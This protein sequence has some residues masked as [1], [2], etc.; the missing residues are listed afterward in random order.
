[1]RPI[2][3]IEYGMH[4]LTCTWAH[5]YTE[6]GWKIINHGF[7]L[8]LII[9]YLLLMEGS[10]IITRLADNLFHLFNHSC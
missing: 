3:Q 1:M 5:I 7:M 10:Q 8:V 4:P 6:W 2:A 9:F